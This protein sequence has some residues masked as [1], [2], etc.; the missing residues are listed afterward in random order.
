[1]ILDADR[2]IKEVGGLA[3]SMATGVTTVASS[4]VILPPERMPTDM[5]HR[6][7][8]AVDLTRDDETEP[9]PLELTEED[10]AAAQ[11]SALNDG[12]AVV[13]VDT[14]DAEGS[15]APAAPPVD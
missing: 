5:T 6:H 13:E 14:V 8:E 10:H 12:S 11:L 1:M 4:V 7:V 15:T 3:G 9:A 2:R